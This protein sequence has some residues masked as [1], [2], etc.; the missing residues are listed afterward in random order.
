M[1]LLLVWLRRALLS[2]VV[3]AAVVVTG[4]LMYIRTGSFARL[5]TRYIS[6]LLAGRFQGEIVVR[7]LDT[8]ISGALTIDD[9]SVRYQGVTIIYIP[10]AHLKYSLIPLLWH[11]VS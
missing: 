4:T 6:G 2:L 3:V 5:L 1:I 10:Q 8:S 7:Q 9:L 11:E